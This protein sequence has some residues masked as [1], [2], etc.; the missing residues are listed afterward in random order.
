[1]LNKINISA[2]IERNK[3]KTGFNTPVSHDLDR[4]EAKKSLAQILFANRQSGK[5]ISFGWSSYL[6]KIETDVLNLLTD[7]SVKSVLVLAHKGP[8]RDAYGSD[9]GICG[10]LKRLGKRPYPLVDSRPEYNFKA[11]PSVK[12]DKPAV[13]YICHRTSSM[14]EWL[15]KEEVEQLDVAVITDT[16][17]PHLTTS[18]A[19]KLVATAKKIIFIDHHKDTEGQHSNLEKWMEAFREYKPD[20]KDEDVLYWRQDNRVAASEMVGDAD[21]EVCLEFD[22]IQKN[23]PTD[24]DNVAWAN[25]YDQGYYTGYRA[26]M[27]AGIINDSKGKINTDDKPEFSFVADYQVPDDSG[28]NV[29]STRFIFDW[30]VNSS[31]TPMSKMKEI[32][33]STIPTWIFAETRDIIKGKK[34]YDG[35]TVIPATEENPLSLLM[36]EELSNLPKLGNVSNRDFLQALKSG[37]NTLSKK[38]KCKMSLM[39]VKSKSHDDFMIHISSK[40]DLA[41]KLIEQLTAQGL[42]DGG[43]PNSSY[44]VFKSKPGVDFDKTMEL[45]NKFMEDVK[46]EELRAAELKA[47]EMMVAEVK[48]EEIK[49]QEIDIAAK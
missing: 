38:A 3:V 30:L 10:I 39:V 16:A 29:N 23:I 48:P 24:P 37:Y 6:P 19:I 42:G 9:V 26:A 12:P 49:N 44:V 8:D 20:L 27:A 4:A 45:I 21:R 41:G 32:L 5:N 18:D 34:V 11:M 1:M 35:I 33:A 47:A 46:A 31:E 15:K 14:L 36:V 7:P 2:Q 22:R 13:E 40:G 17:V 43:G 25:T 28:R